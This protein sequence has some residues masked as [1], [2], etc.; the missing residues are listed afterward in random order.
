MLLPNARAPIYERSL[1]PPRTGRACMRRAADT[2]GSVADDDTEAGVPQE[3]RRKPQA[4]A[5]NT[6]APPSRHME[7]IC[8]LES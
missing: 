1:P 7:M 6:A 2:Q 3:R 5:E 4:R 8:A